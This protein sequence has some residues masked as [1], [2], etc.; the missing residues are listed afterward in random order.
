MLR[1]VSRGEYIRPYG[2]WVI[3]MMGMNNS[4]IMD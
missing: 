1:R 2:A 4:N 3:N